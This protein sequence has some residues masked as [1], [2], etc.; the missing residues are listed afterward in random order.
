MEPKAGWY[1]TFPT[2]DRS[3]SEFAQFL[4]RLAL[5]CPRAETIHLVMDNLSRHRRKSLVDFYG[6]EMAA[7]V[8]GCFTVRYTPKLGS[9]LI[10]AEIEIGLFARQCIRILRDALL[11][12]TLD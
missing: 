10:Q 7:V 9:W 2:P 5:Q 6:S 11:Q 3:G 12:H 1:F 4:L 8:W